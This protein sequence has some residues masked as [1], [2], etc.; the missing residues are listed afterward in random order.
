MTL[1][2]FIREYNES[3]FK[4]VVYLL[5]DEITCLA[6]NIYD[7]YDIDSSISDYIVNDVYPSAKGV[8]D[9]YVSDD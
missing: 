6:D 1:Y 7:E 8:L 5:D 3:D 4:C 2:D 9:I